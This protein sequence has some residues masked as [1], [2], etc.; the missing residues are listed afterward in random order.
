ML[1]GLGEVI[2]GCLAAV[3]GASIAAWGSSDAEEW[4]S[5]GSGVYSSGEIDR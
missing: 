3:K 2:E 4:L 5:Y 1:I